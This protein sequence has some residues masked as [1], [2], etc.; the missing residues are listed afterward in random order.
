MGRKQYN[1]GTSRNPASPVTTND[2]YL[3]N[4]NIQEIFKSHLI[5]ISKREY[6][7]NSRTREEL[8]CLR[9]SVVVSIQ[10]I[11]KEYIDSYSGKLNMT[12][13]E[14]YAMTMNAVER[15]DN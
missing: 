4:S 15:G 8:K 5:F 1:N 2:N 14:H 9:L 13:E 11:Q 10:K 3:Y 12:F 6:K 7:Q